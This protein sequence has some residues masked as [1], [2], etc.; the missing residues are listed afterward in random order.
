MLDLENAIITIDAMGCQTDIAEVIIEQKADYILAVKEKTKK[1]Y[2][3]ILK[4]LFDSLK[5][6]IKNLYNRGSW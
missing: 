2:I 3:K 4:V 6:Q 1:N 5:R